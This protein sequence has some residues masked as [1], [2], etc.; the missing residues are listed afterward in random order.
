MKIA[1]TNAVNKKA[2]KTVPNTYD[3]V[4]KLLI[5]FDQRQIRLH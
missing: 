1:K 2:K 5:N 3:L 4:V